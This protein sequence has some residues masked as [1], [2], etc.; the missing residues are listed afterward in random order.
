MKIS[1][2][3]LIKYKIS[4]GHNKYYP[5]M[6]PYLLGKI[7]KTY[8]IDINNTISTI[9]TVIKYIRSILSNKGKLLIVSDE[10][11]FNTILNSYSDFVKHKRYCLNGFLTNKE[12]IKEDIFIPDCIF[13]FNPDMNINLIKEANLLKIPVIALINTNTNADSYEITYKIPSNNNSISVV[14][15]YSEIL[16]KTIEIAFSDEPLYF[17][18]KYNIYQYK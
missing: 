6:F 11:Y 16:K 1:L 5:S 18:Y 13:I 15:L 14:N 3:D 8:I 10:E 9:Q 12:G 17:R 7:G 2:N 4:I